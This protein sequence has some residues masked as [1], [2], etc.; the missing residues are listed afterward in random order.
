MWNNCV[1]ECRHPLWGGAGTCH[2]SS[3]GGDTPAFCECDA[4]YASR[5]AWGNASCV[6]RLVLVSFYIAL[7]TSS[8]LAAV[9][10]VWD[11][12]RHRR[13]PVRYQVARKMVIRTRA[14]QSVW[15]DNF[16]L[17][18]FVSKMKSLVIATTVGAPLSR[19]VIEAPYRGCFGSEPSIRRIVEV[20]A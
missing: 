6:P 5:D 4:G 11:L 3:G 9:L 14:L 17:E 12:N 15:Y 7:A 10:V 16:A 1:H 19:G 13:L 18:N 20:G 8:V 2:N